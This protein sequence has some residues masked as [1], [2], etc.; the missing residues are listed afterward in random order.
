MSID[1]VTVFPF[2]FAGKTGKKRKKGKKVKFTSQQSL[3]GTP[4]LNNTLSA[5]GRA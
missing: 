5:R 2:N 3:A 4:N 1:S